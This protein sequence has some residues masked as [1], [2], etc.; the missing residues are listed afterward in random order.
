MY[1]TRPVQQ[2][3]RIPQIS[4]RFTDLSISNFHIFFQA[5]QS[6]GNGHR[7]SSAYIYTEGTQ[8]WLALRSAFGIISGS[9]L[10]VKHHQL[11]HSSH[12]THSPIRSLH[13]LFHLVSGFASLWGRVPAFFFLGIL[14]RQLGCFFVGQCWTGLVS[15][16][17]QSIERS[18]S[19]FRFFRSRTELLQA[20]LFD[21]REL[22]SF[23]SLMMTG[24]LRYWMGRDTRILHGGQLPFLLLFEL[25]NLTALGIGR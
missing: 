4:K 18:D 25:R 21:T 1:F 5:H 2:F 9:M 15:A 23:S 13:F 19:L 11:R 8:K 7:H 17:A 14:R 6:E 10:S 16:F 22:G 12:C 24:V 20:A 3:S